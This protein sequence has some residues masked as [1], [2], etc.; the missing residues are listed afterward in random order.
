MVDL[1]QV[2]ELRGGDQL[3]EASAEPIRMDQVAHCVADDQRVSR[4][5]CRR[6]PVL[7]PGIYRVPR[8]LGL[9]LARP[10][11]TNCFRS[12]RQC[13]ATRRLDEDRLS[14]VGIVEQEIGVVTDDRDISGLVSRAR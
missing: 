7:H 10:P 5:A 8:A 11:R 14:R 3:V 6:W 1:G 9:P 2:E 12:E 4:R 13:M